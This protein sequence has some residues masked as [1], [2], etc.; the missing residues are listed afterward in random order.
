ML[1]LRICR[2]E[3]RLPESGRESGHVAA[4]FDRTPALSSHCTLHLLALRDAF[5]VPADDDR[6]RV[7]CADSAAYVTRLAQCMDVIL[8]DA[9]DRQGI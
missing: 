3:Q 6:F 5:R 8:A 9:C 1:P 4:P 2:H 7:I